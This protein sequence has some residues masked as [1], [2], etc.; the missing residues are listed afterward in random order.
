MAR[1]IVGAGSG[2]QSRFVLRSGPSGLPPSPSRDLRRIDHRMQGAMTAPLPDVI[3]YSREG[4]HLCEDARAVL[5]GLL[6]DRAAAGRPASLLRER[7]I[8][9]NPEWE[10]AYGSTIPVVEIGERRLELATSPGRL[11]RFVAEALEGS[12]V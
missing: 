3:L 4:C 10:R 9:T 7:D 1:I 6:E 5:Q 2:V 11:R 12:L 8:A